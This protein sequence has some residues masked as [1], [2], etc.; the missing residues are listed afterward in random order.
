MS[1]TDCIRHRLQGRAAP[2][3]YRCTPADSVRL[4][5]D[6][7]DFDAA[8]AAWRA[9]KRPVKGG[10]FEYRCVYIHSNGKACHYAQRGTFSQYCKKHQRYP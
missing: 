9:N 7:I 10:A 5:D 4:P 2:F 1:D 3:R 8:S 6:P